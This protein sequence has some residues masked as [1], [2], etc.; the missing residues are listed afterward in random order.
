MQGRSPVSVWQNS[1][2]KEMSSMATNPPL[3]LLKA[4]SNTT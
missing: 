3:A 1:G 2:E 4:T